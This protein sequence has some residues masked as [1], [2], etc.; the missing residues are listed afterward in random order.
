MPSMRLGYRYEQVTPGA[1]VP[2]RLDVK[3]QRGPAGFAE[4]SYQRQGDVVFPAR[5]RVGSGKQ[6]M[7]VTF[8]S[9]AVE[10]RTR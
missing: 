10:P 5:V 6:T 7:S 8:S 2:A 1:Y 9:F 4:F 3:P